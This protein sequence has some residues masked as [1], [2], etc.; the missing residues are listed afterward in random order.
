MP[1][2]KY[3]YICLNEFSFALDVSKI[4]SIK[5][6]KLFNM[7]FDLSINIISFTVKTILHS[8]FIFSSLP[9]SVLNILKAPNFLYNFWRA[10][11]IFSDCANSSDFDFTNASLS[12]L[13]L[14]DI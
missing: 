9:T 3:L 12:S 2:D 11:L 8:I 1:P 6:L 10:S 4:F 5:A 13:I 14:V 7:G